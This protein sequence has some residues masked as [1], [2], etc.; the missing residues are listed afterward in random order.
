MS[1]CSRLGRS[2]FSKSMNI[3]VYIGTN[4]RGIFYGDASGSAPAPTS[5][6]ASTSSIAPTSTVAPTTSASQASTSSAASSATTL[7]AS[8]TTTSSG[9][10]ATQT[11]YGQCGGT[12]FLYVQ[13]SNSNQIFQA[14]DGRAPLSVFLDTPA[15]SA[16]LVSS[17][18]TR[19]FVSI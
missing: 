15:P 16:T 6:I 11:A 18:I 3:S 4:G 12:C 17:R 2:M 13:N 14:K 10:A 7:S 8:M 19:Q 1:V 5:S 9:S